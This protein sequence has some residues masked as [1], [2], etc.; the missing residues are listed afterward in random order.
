ML[1]LV[2]D[3][4]VIFFAVQVWY[5]VKQQ[6]PEDK[7]ATEIRVMAQ[8]WAW[9]FIHPG[10]DN[11]LGTAD[12]IKTTDD[13]Y[14]RTDQT[15]IYHLESRDVMHDFS[16]PVFRLKQDAIPGRVITGWFKTNDHLPDKVNGKYKPYDIQCAEMCGI[17]H[18]IM[19]ARIFIQDPTTHAKWITGRPETKAAE[20]Q[21]AAKK[22]QAAADIVDDTSALATVKRR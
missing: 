19:N 3:V 1:V 18:G 14:V 13:L 10:K 15:Y 5:N 16:V 12:D 4:F 6:L 7:N 8:Q 2:C 17:G 22:K 9:T 21:K 11:K 20:A